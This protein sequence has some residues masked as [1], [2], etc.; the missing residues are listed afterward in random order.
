MILLDKELK[1]PIFS[2][3]VLCQTSHEQLICSPE[4][5]IF[6]AGTPVFEGGLYSSVWWDSH[7]KAKRALGLTFFKS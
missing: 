3:S 6:D 5:P 1:I 7:F 4:L 2:N